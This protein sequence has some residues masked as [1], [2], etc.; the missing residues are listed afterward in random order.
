MTSL[1]FGNIKRMP[2]IGSISLLSGLVPSTHPDTKT[3]TGN[4][5]VLYIDTERKFSAGRLVEIAAA[6]AADLN[7]DPGGSVPHPG[8]PA[9]LA[10][11]VL[12]ASPASAP[13]LLSMLQ[14]R[15]HACV[16]AAGAVLSTGL[17]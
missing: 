15:R 10:V 6:R 5:Q 13:E 17:A 7:P 14:V 4:A 16:G 12:V 2:C 9:T 3:A 1:L 8:D 11:R